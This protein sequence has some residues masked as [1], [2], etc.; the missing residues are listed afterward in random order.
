[1]GEKHTP[2]TVKMIFLAENLKIL[3]SASIA[4]DRSCANGLSPSPYNDGKR[5]QIGFVSEKFSLFLLGDT[6]ASK[7]YFFNRSYN[8]SPCARGICLQGSR[9]RVRTYFYPKG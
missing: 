1:M 8:S 4:F 5:E 2:R 7:R 3:L 6:F 9:H